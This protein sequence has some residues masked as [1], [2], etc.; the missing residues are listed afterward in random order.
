MGGR[1]VGW[2]EA[3][4]GN[5]CILQLIHVLWQKRTQHCKAIYPPIKY[6][7]KVEYTIKIILRKY[8]IKSKIVKTIGQSH[9]KYK[10]YFCERLRKTDTLLT[11]MVKKRENQIHK[12]KND[13]NNQEV[14]S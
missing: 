5:T 9:S 2:E 4:G 14:I 13:R 1:E 7:L 8:I 3:Q 12:I 6:F 11:G 10:G